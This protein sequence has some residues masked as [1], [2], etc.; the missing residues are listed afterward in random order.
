MLIAGPGIMIGPGSYKL[1]DPPVI[2]NKQQQ[3]QE[4]LRNK[5]ALDHVTQNI[6]KHFDEMKA[7]QEKMEE[8]RSK[9]HRELINVLLNFGSSNKSNE[10]EADMTPQISDKSKNVT[11][12]PTSQPNPDHIMVAKE[13]NPQTENPNNNSS[14]CP[15]L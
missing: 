5:N 11:T 6:A 12:R 1:I 14:L 10:M 7:S 3:K 9:E 2:L 8:K 4:N 15:F 13:V